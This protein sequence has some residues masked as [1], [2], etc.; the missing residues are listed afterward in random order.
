MKFVFLKAILLIAMSIQLT[1][2]AAFGQSAFVDRRAQ[3]RAAFEQFYSLLHFL[4]ADDAFLSRLTSDERLQFE[5]LHKTI[6]GAGFRLGPGPMPGSDNSSARLNFNLKFSNNPNDFVLNPGQPPRTAKVAQDVWFNLNII[7]DPKVQFNLLD[8]FQILLHEFG[9]KLGEVK[10]QELVDRVAVKMRGHLQSYYREKV[11][12]TGFKGITFV[13]P[14]LIA[15]RE[16]TVDMQVEPIV[17]LEFE[18]RI[19][20]LKTNAISISYMFQGVTR[21]R[22]E[23]QDFARVSMTPNFYQQSDGLVVG[24]EIERKDFLIQ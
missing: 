8:T 9:H 19:G 3:V 6:I 4:S 22:A 11:I 18:G 20:Q 5:M 16:Y 1:A 10:N 12:D 24:W 2:A 13:L 14:Y 17:L 15:D 21:Y 7:N 23:I